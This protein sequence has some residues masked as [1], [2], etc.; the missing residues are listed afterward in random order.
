MQCRG[1]GLTLLLGVTVSPA[2]PALLTP[3][4]LTPGLTPTSQGALPTLTFNREASPYQNSLGPKDH[5]KA[6][7]PESSF[8]V[9]VNDFCG[10]QKNEIH[11]Q[12]NAQEPS[13]KD[14]GKPEIQTQKL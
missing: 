13:F 7:S 8:W 12:G 9:Q 3:A 14:S 10:F 2:A 5:M 4:L 1:V 6:R 11:S